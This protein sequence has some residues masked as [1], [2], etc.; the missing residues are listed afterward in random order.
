MEI[1]I[2]QVSEKCQK[3]WE[4]WADVPLEQPASLGVMPVPLLFHRSQSCLSW[5]RSPDR[6]KP[7]GSH[8]LTTLYIKALITVY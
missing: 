7:L 3:T 6:G 1:E 2:F 5:R 4:S 8:G